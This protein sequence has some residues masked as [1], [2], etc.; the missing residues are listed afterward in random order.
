MQSAPG[1]PY[2]ERLHGVIVPNFDL[3]KERKIVNT[4]EILRYEV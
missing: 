3:M 4:R 2:S 1:E